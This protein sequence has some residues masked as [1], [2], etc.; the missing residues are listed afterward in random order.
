LYE[1]YKKNSTLPEVSRNCV[2]FYNHEETN[3]LY[4]DERT[5]L[6]DEYRDQAHKAYNCA[7]LGGF[8]LSLSAAILSGSHENVFIT[9]TVLMSCSLATLIAKYLISPRNDYKWTVASSVA[10][11]NF[12]LLGAFPLKYRIYA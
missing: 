4:S 5:R 8:C 9:D 2:P 10:I 12:I 7:Q 1:G 6:F 11:S 3:P